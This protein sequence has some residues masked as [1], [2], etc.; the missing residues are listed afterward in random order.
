MAT[1]TPTRKY[2]SCAEALCRGCPPFT[3]LEGD[4]NGGGG[5]DDGCGNGDDGGGDDDDDGASSSAPRWRWWCPGSA[6]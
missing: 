3:Q 4:E 6:S 5:D 1:W 2:K